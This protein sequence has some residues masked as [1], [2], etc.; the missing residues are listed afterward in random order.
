MFNLGNITDKNDN[1]WPYRSLIIGPSG[2]GI[3]CFYST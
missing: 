2:S 1:N 3:K